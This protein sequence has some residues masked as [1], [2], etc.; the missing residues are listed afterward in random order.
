VDA[1]HPYVDSPNHLSRYWVFSGVGATLTGLSFPFPGLNYQQADVLGEESRLRPAA[2]NGNDW[3][4]LSGGSVNPGAN[5]LATS[6]TSPISI[7]G[8]EVTGKKCSFRYVWVGTDG[9]WQIPSNWTPTRILPAREDTLVIGNTAGAFT[10][11]NVPHQF[12]ASLIVYPDVRATLV[13]SLSTNV[14]TVSDSL[15][16]IPDLL[17]FPTGGLT[18]GTGLTLNI[19]TYSSVTGGLNILGDLSVNGRL[20]LG[21]TLSYSGNAPFWGNS[22][23]LLYDPTLGIAGGNHFITMGNEAGNSPNEVRILLPVNTDPTY[24]QFTLGVD[25]T[26]NI[27]DLRYKTDG[28]I[29]TSGCSGYA[30]HAL[31]IILNGRT[32]RINSNLRNYGFST[33]QFRGSPNSSLILGGIGSLS[34]PL[35]FDQ[36][37]PG[38]TNALAEFTI[39]RLGTGNVLLGNS[40]FIYS[41][42]NL[43]NGRLD[44]V[45]NSLSLACHSITRTTAGILDADMGTV[46]FRNSVPLT[47]PSGLFS[48]N[49]NNLTVDSGGGVTHGSPTTVS[50]NFTLMNGNFSLGA[51]DLNLGT[52]VLSGGS[53]AG[54]VKTT[55]IGRLRRIVSSTD[56]LFPVGRAYY[57][58]V[59]IRNLTG[60]DDLFS[61]RVDDAVYL[62]GQSGAQITEKRINA[63]WFIDK[64]T[65]NS[66]AGTGVDFTFYWNEVQKLPGITE[67]TLNHHDGTGWKIPIS[68]GTPSYTST[69][70][71]FP[72]YKGTFS[73]FAIGQGS[74]PLPVVLRSFKAACSE[75]R[76]ELEWI[77]ES[78][79]NNNLFTVFRSSDLKAWEEVLT[80]PGAGNSNALLTYTAYDERP[81]EGISYYRLKQTDY[82]GTSENSYPISNFCRDSNT[83]A[84]WIV[85]PNPTE[86]VFILLL[87]GHP[88]KGELRVDLTDLGGRV[89]KVFSIPPSN[90]STYYTADMS[91]MPA[92][93]YLLRKYVKGA[94]VGNP[95]KIILR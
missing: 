40:L 80:L 67:F 2:W 6:L 90:G 7:D 72:G 20:R 48:G 47:L 78:E 92:G 34:S 25:L 83:G 54:Y 89:L 53:A 10:I 86:G 79:I 43:T 45:E 21:G 77:T 76:V 69:Q 62:N 31:T 3:I 8:L 11:N 23:R 41:A 81:Y 50:G 64:V 37:E 49:V 52:A 35:Y 14:L 22:S 19:N 88:E 75:G 57:N 24:M 73:P 13:P 26:T 93:I 74:S 1:A 15:E 60:T 29:C 61:L 30:N 91:E 85:Y 17:I 95:L 36:A 68:T 44:L 56:A 51:H 84:D 94:I 27:L 65:P 87:A 58:P 16:G 71:S 18:V 39:N 32:L 38:I 66:L 42:L 4:P 12:I 46:L 63:T 70:L 59:I 55:G 5:R 28:T 33:H 9:D 82:D